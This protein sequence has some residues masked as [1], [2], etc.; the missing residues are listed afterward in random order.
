MH[1]DEMNQSVYYIANLVDLESIEILDEENVTLLHDD[2]DTPQTTLKQMIKFV[3]FQNIKEIWSISVGNSSKIKH[4]VILLQNNGHICSCLSILRC[5]IVCRHYFQVMLATSNAMFHI[6]L[7]PTRWYNGERNGS[8]ELFIFADKYMQ[9]QPIIT[10]DYHDAVPYLCSIKDYREE[11]LSFLEQKIAYG[12]LHNAYKKAL[13]KALQTDFNSQ[14]LINLLEEFAENDNIDEQSESDEYEDDIND[15]E[16]VNPTLL[17]NPKPHRGKGRPMG[18]KRI[19][20]AHEIPNQRTKHQ[21]RCK[22]CRN[23]SHYQKNCKI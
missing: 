18:T 11:S 20:S 9:K 23:I 17:K 5:G 19:K 14:N 15:K 1:Q 22:K 13:K 6:R 7:I 4:Y 12:K 16:N 8:N 21:R 3:E 10:S 2:I